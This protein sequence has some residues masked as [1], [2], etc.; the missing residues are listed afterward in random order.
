[1]TTHP[2]PPAI[3]FVEAAMV[4]G[5]P[6]HVLDRV[7]RSPDVQRVINNLPPWLPV[8]V[9]ATVQAI[10]TAASRYEAQPMRS[11]ETPIGEIEA[12]SDRVGYGWLNVEQ[13][14]SQ[15]D[16]TPR[17][18]QQLA[19]GGMGHRVGRVWRLDP[20]AVHAYARRRRQAR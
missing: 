10:R 5:A 12:R 15:L 20:T 9:T 16:V 3:P 11:D 2:T 14:A 18:V 19:A 8:E 13:A 6:A 4:S 7:L 17:R 1:M